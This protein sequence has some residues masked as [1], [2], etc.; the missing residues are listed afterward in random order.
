MP[1]YRASIPYLAIAP[2]ATFGNPMTW[3]FY[4]RTPAGAPKWL[5]RQQCESGRDRNRS[6]A[7]PAG[8][9]IYDGNRISPERCIGEHSVT[10]NEPLQ[11]WLLLY[12]CRYRPGE[13]PQIEARI[14]PNPWGP[15][16]PPTIV[17][18][19]AQYP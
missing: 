11:S 10:W 16:S 8:A 17:L 6:W 15:W 14:A 2:A 12:G 5:T 19:L 18:S 3:S 9:E 13:I 4:S 1:L 7:P